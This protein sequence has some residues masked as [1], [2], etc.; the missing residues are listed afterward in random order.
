[1]AHAEAFEGGVG[2]IVSGDIGNG[3]N[4]NRD[5]ALQRLFFI[6]ILHNSIIW[7]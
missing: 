6:K 1:M 5:V 3:E 7:I 4:N 2:L